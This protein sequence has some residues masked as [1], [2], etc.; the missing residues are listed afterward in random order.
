[1][2]QILDLITYILG[3]FENNFIFIQFKRLKIK[4]LGYD[5]FLGPLM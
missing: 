3:K 4:N 1:M 5:I 2:P